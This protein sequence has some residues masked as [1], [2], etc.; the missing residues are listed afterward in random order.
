MIPINPAMTM[1]GGPIRVAL[2]Q[3]NKHHQKLRHGEYPRLDRRN[4]R[5]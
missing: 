1:E 4:A 5:K 3:G 2:V